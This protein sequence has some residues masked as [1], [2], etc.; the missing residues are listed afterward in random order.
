MTGF[1]NRAFRDLA[2]MKSRELELMEDNAAIELAD[3]LR[4]LVNQIYGYQEKQ[5]NEMGNN[6]PS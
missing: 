4:K 2:N 6:E 1:E 5:K 3:Q